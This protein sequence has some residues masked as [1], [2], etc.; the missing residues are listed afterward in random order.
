M[1]IADL[2]PEERRRA[3]D[4]IEW[5]LGDEAAQVDLDLAI[6]VREAMTR[7]GG[8]DW[9]AAWRAAAGLV[10]RWVHSREGG[11]EARM[12]EASA[13]IPL[14][15]E[16]LVQEAARLLNASLAPVPRAPRGRAGVR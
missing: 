2:T 3:L 8:A 6:E 7:P 13:S 15:R 9:D 16:E 1:P 5:A 4:A 11:G 14:E 10:L 12:P